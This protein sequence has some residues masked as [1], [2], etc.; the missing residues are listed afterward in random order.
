MNDTELDRLLETWEA[1]APRPALREGLRARFP[2]PE[3]LAFARPLRWALATLLL[4]VALAIG[5]AQAQSSYSRLD[6]WD[7]PIVRFLNHMYESFVEEREARRVEGVIAKIKQSEPKVYVDG[8]LVALLEYGPA[9]SMDVQVP[10][11]G[12][13]SISLY[14]F[15]GLRNAVGRP[16]GWVEA[17]HIHDGVIEFQAGGKS[18]RI[19]CNQ[20]IV[21]QDGP[22]F[23]MHRP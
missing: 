19:E 11:E 4:S 8:R 15:T 14:R 7:L 20:P 17:G 22:V 18:V 1:P 16:T 10:G 12:L 3:R 21:D 6:F 9:Q 13:Y 2:R 23:A 5:V